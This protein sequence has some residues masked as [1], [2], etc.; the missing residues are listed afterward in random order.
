MKKLH[1]SPF[2]PPIP[3]GCDCEGSATFSVFPVWSVFHGVTM[4]GALFYQAMH[5]LLINM[6]AERHPLLMEEPK[7]MGHAM[8]VFGDVLV[9]AGGGGG[10]DEISLASPAAR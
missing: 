6:A 10:E 9:A 1:E 3:S 4:C 7:A 2:P 5:S 8:S